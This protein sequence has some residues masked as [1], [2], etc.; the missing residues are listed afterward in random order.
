MFDTKGKR[1]SHHRKMH[2]TFTVDGAR[3]IR[4]QRS[5]GGK[6]VCGCGNCYDLVYSL[7]IHQRDCYASIATIEG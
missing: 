6:F 5:A 2:Q 7:R 4:V 1:D 3:E